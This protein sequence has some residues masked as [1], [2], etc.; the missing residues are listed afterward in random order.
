M[1]VLCQKLA[2]AVQ[3]RPMFTHN[4]PD[5][6]QIQSVP[7][8]HWSNFEGGRSCRAVPISCVSCH[9]TR[10]PRSSRFR[11]MGGQLRGP[12]S[13]GRRG[14]WDKEARGA[15]ME[16]PNNL[17]MRKVGLRELGFGRGALRC[18][19]ALAVMGSS[20]SRCSRGSKLC[21]AECIRAHTPSGDPPFCSSCL[22]FS[23]LPPHRPHEGSL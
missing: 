20:G 1:S 19:G 2:K 7:V 22:F 10:S 23:R 16:P 9:F 18:D 5:S 8:Q 4:W 15:E 3:I 14:G 21:K 6:R 17:L 11:G 12:L 13:E